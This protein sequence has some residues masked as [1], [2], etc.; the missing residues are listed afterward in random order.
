M[1]DQTT[2]S[3]ISELVSQL[4]TDGCNYAALLREIE[5]QK[6]A[7]QQDGDEVK[8]N[9]LWSY[10]ILVDVH[11]LFFSMFNELQGKKYYDAWCTAEQVDINIKLLRKN[12]TE[13]YG[14]V[15]DLEL[16]LPDLQARYPYKLFMS[17]VFEINKEVCTIC[18]QPVNVRKPCGHIVGRVYNG[19][20]CQHRVEMFNLL[21]ADMVANPEHKYAVL[22]PQF[23]D[24]QIDLYDYT[25]VAFFIKNWKKPFDIR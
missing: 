17:T 12:D 24:K 1:N 22:F 15:R 14:Y 6:Y 19:E 5:T 2:I 20:L 23:G 7:V 4:R 9:K 13:A 25:Q 11:R 21:G 18:G 3:P 16:F 10:E 8:A